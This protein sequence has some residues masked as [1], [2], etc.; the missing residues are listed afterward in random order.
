MATT[1]YLITD[2]VKNLMTL[3]DSPAEYLVIQD[4]LSA[5]EADIASD[6]K[7]AIQQVQN[8]IETVS[9][10]CWGVFE[11]LH[12][13]KYE[14]LS[15]EDGEVLY[16]SQDQYLSDR[17][18]P[19]TGL[20]RSTIFKYL[21]AMRVGY[22]HG[23]TSLDDLIAIGGPTR[24]YEIADFFAVERGTGQI[25]GPKGQ[26]PDPEINYD[27]EVKEVISRMKSEE[28]DLDWKKSIHEAA[29]YREP[30]VSLDLITKQVVFNQPMY[31]NGTEYCRQVVLSRINGVDPAFTEWVEGKS[32]LPVKV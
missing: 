14:E 15:G 18:I 26:E 10:V 7:L 5:R 21:K 13:R 12:F 31:D 1:G 6:V 25:I 2:N 27:E 16:K 11:I 24:L 17:L 22:E 19:A 28:P 9:R 4:D 29:N 3:V 20:A 8:L 23:V 32:S 30:W